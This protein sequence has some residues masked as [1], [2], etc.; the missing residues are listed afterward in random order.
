MKDPKINTKVVHSES[1]NAWNIIGISLAK[2]YKVARIPYLI[3]KDCPNLNETRKQEALI[4][5]EFISSCF[6]KSGSLME[7]IKPL[8]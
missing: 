4:H 8:E 2:K 5:A 3:I 1:K 6:N 7:L